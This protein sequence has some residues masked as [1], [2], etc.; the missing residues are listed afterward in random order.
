MPISRR[1]ALTLASLFV[2]SP[3]LP[4]EGRAEQVSV[5]SAASFDM[6]TFTATSGGDADAAFA[7]ALAAIA[8]AAAEAAKAGPA[9]IVLNLEKNTS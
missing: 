2:A 7:K 9:H 8:K 1:R 3:L 5:P 6:A 4:T